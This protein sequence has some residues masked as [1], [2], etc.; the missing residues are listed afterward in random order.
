M[1]IKQLVIVVAVLALAAVVTFFLR[2]PAP[3]A[4]A[5]ARLGQNLVDASTLQKTAKI[6]VSEA[7]KSI[8]LTKD[9]AGAWRIQTY[10]NL[11]ASFPKIAEFLADY[12]DTKIER[13]VS[14]N[15]E[16]IARLGFGDG[17]VELFDTAGTT[18]WSLTVG[19]SSESGGHFLRFGDEAK[20]YY[21]PLRTYLDTEPINWAEQQLIQHTADDIA[22]VE[23]SFPKE[24]LTIKAS[25]PGKDDP[26][27]AVDAPGGRKLRFDAI[28]T[29]VTS[30][31]SL[32]FSNTSAVDNPEARALRADNL[33]TLKLTTFGGQTYTIEMSARI[34][35]PPTPPTATDG[36]PPPPVDPRDSIP[37]AAFVWIASSLESAPVN[38]LMKQRTFHMNEY[39]YASLPAKSDDLFEAP[40]GATVNQPSAP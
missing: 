19:R 35:P 18:I 30:F 40:A 27:V 3:A 36:T 13:V 39:L 7:G 33:R 15:P 22:A 38:G 29:L 9:A 8:E 24:N 1:K 5:D 21:A 31:A 34:P 4:A 26:F 17:R 37:T 6:K 14:T 10:F 11:P 23:L 12:A 28:P 16:R 2:R 20:A 25:R 32:R